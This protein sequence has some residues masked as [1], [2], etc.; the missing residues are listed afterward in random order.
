MQTLEISRVMNTD[1][2]IVKQGEELMNEILGR[3]ATD[4]AFRAK[5]IADPRSAVA[6]FTGKAVDASFNVIFIENHAGAT[7]VL[8]DPV[9]TA[10]ELSDGELESVA[11]GSELVVATLCVVASAIALTR[12]IFR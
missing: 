4:G 1:P 3:S 5:L 8:P 2:A 9:D 11:G 6:E 10:A 7:L 12:A